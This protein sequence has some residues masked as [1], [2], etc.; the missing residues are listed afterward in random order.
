MKY[1]LL[2]IFACS[3]LGCSIS[4]ASSEPE[5]ITIHC[6]VSPDTWKRYSVHADSVT[7]FSNFQVPNGTWRFKTTK[8]VMVYSTICHAEI[9]FVGTI[10]ICSYVF[11]T[12]FMFNYNFAILFLVLG[13]YFLTKYQSTLKVG[14]YFCF[15]ARKL[16]YFSPQIPGKKYNKCFYTQRFTYAQQATI[17]RALEEKSR[18]HSANHLP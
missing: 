7:P 15:K 12:I 1:L 13:L 5:L 4:Q 14:T 18:S 10:T 2:A 8:G 3:S 16:I 9:W 11:V 17:Q 6:Q